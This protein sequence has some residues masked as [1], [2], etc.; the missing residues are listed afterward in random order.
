MNVKTMSKIRRRKGAEKRKNKE[1]A[2]GAATAQTINYNEFNWFCPE[3]T[4]EKSTEAA[5][6]MPPRVIYSRS[7]T[8]PIHIQPSPGITTD[9]WPR[10]SSTTPTNPGVILE[11]IAN[12]YNLTTVQVCELVEGLTNARLLLGY[13]HPILRQHQPP[14]SAA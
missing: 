2:S 10:R 8:R 13:K 1:C 11:A 14:F 9:S 5:D 12:A 4:P 3:N 7:V 6:V